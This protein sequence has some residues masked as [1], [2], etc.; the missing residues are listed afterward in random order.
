MPPAAAALV[1]G[2]AYIFP[3]AF[4][5]PNL[6]LQPVMVRWGS[7]TPPVRRLSGA[8]IALAALMIALPLAGPVSVPVMV[9]LLVAVGICTGVIESSLAGLASMLPG[10]YLQGV[11]LGQSTSG[12][13]AN[14]LAWIVRLAWGN[15]ATHAAILYFTLGGAFMIA[16]VLLSMWMVRTPVARHYVVTP[17]PA[18]RVAARGDVESPPAVAVDESS[19]L[20]LPSPS[21]LP[22]GKGDGGETAGEVELVAASLRPAASTSELLQRKQS[23]RA[24]AGA[25]SPSPS[26]AAP[27]PFTCANLGRIL[28]RV[29]PSV[30]TI[31]LCYLCTFLVFPSLVA[32]LQ[33][34]AAPLGGEPF[35]ADSAKWTLLLFSAYAVADVAGRVAA[36]YATSYVTAAALLTYAAA[37]FATVVV[38]V[39]SLRSFAGLTSDVAS[40]LGVVALAFSMGHCTALAMMWGPRQVA[41]RD[42]QLCGF[43]HIVAL[44]F[45]IFTGSQG[46][47][48]FR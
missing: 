44:H 1:A 8:G 16:F 37:R 28:S 12:L 14:V 29:W 41:D 21:P 6:A 36:N 25:M 17:A 11:L 47:L 32:S 19:A 38:L 43:C 24:V 26:P 27:L 39:G 2:I 18:V 23:A 3:I 5:Y 31:F 10:V 22:A 42:R 46:A 20:A 33:Y 4:A 35:L 40:M 9:A 34:H 30:I 48:A 15:S 45:G 13:V 7:L